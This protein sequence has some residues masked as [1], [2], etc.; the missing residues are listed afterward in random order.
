[1]EESTQQWGWKR[2]AVR[3]PEIG[4]AEPSAHEGA[5]EAR[6]TFISSG[7]QFEGTLKLRGDFQIDSDFRGEL[8]TDG[9]VVVGPSGSVE[10]NIHANEVE[11]IGAV[12]GDIAAKRE[13]SL[14]AG[15]RLHGEVT[16]ACLLIERHAFFCGTT[17]MTEP[18][19][20]SR[21]HVRDTNSAF[22]TAIRQEPIGAR[23]ARPASGKTGAAASVSTTPVA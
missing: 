19:R 17:A 20:L 14:R 9:K 5:T 1:M 4:A 15:S 8:R 23:A 11:I 13:V 10:G 16:T 2:M 21:G 18:Q 3:E 12:V 7:A 22:D 6:S